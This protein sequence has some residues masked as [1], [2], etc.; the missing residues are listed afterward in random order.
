MAK[1]CKYLINFETPKSIDQWCS[2]PNPDGNI[3]QKCPFGMEVKCPL[4]IHRI[5]ITDKKENTNRKV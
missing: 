2:Q 5:S 4:L 1:K 3:F